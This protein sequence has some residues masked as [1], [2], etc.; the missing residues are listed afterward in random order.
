MSNTRDRATRKMQT[1]SSAYGV[2][3][4]LPA[5]RLRTEIFAEER[6]DVVL[7]T[8][9]YLTGMSARIDFEAVY[10]SVLVENV[11]QL[12]GVHA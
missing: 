5:T 11:M 4:L 3:C 6:H 1:L 2:I 10:D 9:G 8:V 7:K 12:S